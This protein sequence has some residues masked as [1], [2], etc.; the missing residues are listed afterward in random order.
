MLNDYWATPAADSISCCCGCSILGSRE[1][2]IMQ[3]VLALRQQPQI[4]R[5]AQAETN[6][7][8][9]A[10]VPLTPLS[11]P[12]PVTPRSLDRSCSG[13]RTGQWQQRQKKQVINPLLRHATASLSLSSGVSTTPLYV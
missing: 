4:A 5:G 2:R 11:A 8:V 12:L 1:E 13:T 3:I 6:E 10:A 9:A 7:F